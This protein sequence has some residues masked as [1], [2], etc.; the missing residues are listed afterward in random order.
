V[1]SQ[2]NSIDISSTK[3]VLSIIFLSTTNEEVYRVHD[4]INRQN[5]DEM[6]ATLRCFVYLWS[7]AIMIRIRIVT[8]SSLSIYVNYK[9]Q[10]MS[11]FKYSKIQR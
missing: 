8:R 6:R 1:R 9:L 11:H 5:R 2:E 10:L 7:I 4:D 3:P